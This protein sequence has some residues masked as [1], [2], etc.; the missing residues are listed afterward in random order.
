M[1]VMRGAYTDGV[2]SRS[3]ALGYMYGPDDVD[4]M[5]LATEPPTPDGI[6]RQERSMYLF[7]EKYKAIGAATG[8]LIIVHFV[9]PLETLTEYQ[10]SSAALFDTAEELARPATG[11]GWV[12]SR[13][14]CKT[15][16]DGKTRQRSSSGKWLLC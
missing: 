13:G 3:V 8:K 1:A 7:D 11:G 16:R 12:T 5:M 9:T 15:V 14:R 2:S 6:E 4:M 10:E